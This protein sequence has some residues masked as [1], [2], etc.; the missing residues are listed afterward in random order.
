MLLALHE[1]VDITSNLTYESQYAKSYNLIF[2]PQLMYDCTSPFR[3]EPVPIN[4]GD[5]VEPDGIEQIL[6]VFV[7]A[8]EGIPLV[9]E[10]VVGRKVGD[11]G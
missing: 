2:F 1:A 4:V 9:G 6:G 3:N 10:L 11:V 5:G 8:W 7:G